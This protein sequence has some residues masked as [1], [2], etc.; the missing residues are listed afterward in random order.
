MKRFGFFAFWLKK[1]KCPLLLVQNIDIYIKKC[2][3]NRFGKILY[4]HEYRPQIPKK[5]NASRS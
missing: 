1:K 4:R 3:W 5:G 2:L